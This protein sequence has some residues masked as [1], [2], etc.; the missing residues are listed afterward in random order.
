MKQWKKTVIACSLATGL[1]LTNVAPGIIN[2][3]YAAPRTKIQIVQVKHQA[4]VQKIKK[5]AV[6]GKTVNSDCF[7]IGS[8]VSHIK[9]KW[10]K[11]DAGSDNRYL[12]YSKHHISF[13]AV[14][15]KVTKIYS[16]DKSYWNITY[17]EVRKSL[18]KPVK[19]VKGEDA[20]YLT[21]KAGKHTLII[22][23]YYDN[24]GTGPS[25]IKEVTVQ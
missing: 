17:K 10:G 14:G 7:G 3:S 9:K 19:E 24:K 20:V 25:T 16:T 13:E 2:H 8:K 23:F 21:Y 4:Q 12:S 6:A 22:A 1:V 11:P 5:F 18:G 15:G